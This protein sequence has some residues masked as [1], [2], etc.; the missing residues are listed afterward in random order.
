MKILFAALFASLLFVS[1]ARAQVDLC[2]DICTDCA[3]TATDALAVLNCAVGLCPPAGCSSTTTTL[4]PT[5]TLG[6]TTTMAP[7]TTS[8][9]TTTT[10]QSL[11]C[12]L[13][14]APACVSDT[15]LEGW[16]LFV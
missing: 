2:V 13:A 16:E 7:T 6:P 12:N 15:C 3:L 5:T 9:T 1:P 14:E 8:S 11:G 4:A 10:V